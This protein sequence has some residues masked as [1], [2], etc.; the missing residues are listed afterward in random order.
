MVGD[1]LLLHRAEGPQPHM[2][3]HIAQPD[4][5]LLHLAQQLR[6]EVQAGGG[7]G[8]GPQHF[9]VDGLIPLVVLELRLDIGGRGIRPSSSR[10][11]RKIPW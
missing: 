2:E 6:R 10:I 11:S 4:P 7:S 5:H 1:L 9:G 8:G 3:R